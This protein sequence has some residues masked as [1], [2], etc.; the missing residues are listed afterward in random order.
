[1]SFPDTADTQADIDPKA[2]QRRAFG[3]DTN[4]QGHIPEIDNGD[5]APVVEK[6]EAPKVREDPRQAKEREIVE[7]VNETR[8]HEKDQADA[9]LAKPVEAGPAPEKVLKDDD[10]VDLKV[11]KKPYRM[12]VKDRNEL[13]REDYDDDDI[14]AMSEKDRNSQAQMLMARREYSKEI[15]DLKNQVNNSSKPTQQQPVQQ[16]APAEPAPVEKS[17]VEL[18]Q[19]GYDKALEDFEYGKENARPALS[20][21][22]NE[23]F[24]AQAEIAATQQLDSRETSRREQVFVSDVEAGFTAAEQIIRDA[25][26]QALNDP[27]IRGSM[28]AYYDMAYR[29]IIAK[30]IGDGGPESIQAF[31][32]HG[33]TPDYLANASG[34]ELM[35][36]YKDMTFKRYK[37]PRP[38]EVI[39][40]VAGNIASRLS[41]NTQPAPTGQHQEPAPSGEAQTAPIDRSERKDAIRHQPGRASMPQG[42]SDAPRRQETQAERRSRVLAEERQKR[43]G[44]P[45]GR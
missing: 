39:R 3:V 27:I 9:A 8:R 33:V 25:N 6:E 11:R 41:G 44:R 4:D 24:Q 22:Q 2:E 38:S 31:T 29:A 32:A 1:M 23:L 40:T 37:L 45:T 10:Y 36:L 35:Y 28:P 26:P 5:T 19:E 42:Q 12:T 43:K 30:A 7:R 17:R 21:A 16:A 13:L 34:P 14:K 15:E 20:A 18:A